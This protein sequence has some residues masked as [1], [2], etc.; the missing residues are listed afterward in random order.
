MAAM[1]PTRLTLAPLDLRP[2]VLRLLGAIV[3]LEFVPG[4]SALYLIDEGSGQV[5]V[6][7]SGNGYNGTLGSTAGVDA[8]TDPVRVPGGGVLLGTGQYAVIPRTTTTRPAMS[9]FVS[10]ACRAGT[11]AF[12]KFQAGAGKREWTIRVA[13]NDLHVLV[14]DNGT[15]STHYKD[16]TVA[17][18]LTAE[19]H[20]VGFTFIAGV[21]TLYL[22]GVPQTP[23]AI[24]ADHPIT[25]V[26]GSTAPMVIGG[27]YEAG[28]P[29]NTMSGG[30][31]AAAIVYDSAALAPTQALQVHTYLKSIVASR[32][33][34]PPQIKFTW[35][36][37]GIAIRDI[38]GR[39]VV[40]PSFS[41][42]RLAEGKAYYVD[43][44]AGSDADTGLSA[45]HALA[46]VGAALAKADIDTLYIMS[47]VYDA[48]ETVGTSIPRPLNMIGV[49]TVAL[50]C[51]ETP[52][53]L[54]WLKTAGK[55]NVYECTEASAISRIFDSTVP[56]ATSGDWS[57]LALQTSTANVDANAGS[58]Y[59]DGTTLY[60]HTHDH[61]TPDAGVYIFLAGLRCLNNDL[62]MNMY[63]E[64]ITFLGGDAPVY[65]AN[66]A[67][68]LIPSAAMVRCTAK[69]SYGSGFTV[70]GASTFFEE[71][72]AASNRLDG[73]NYHIS[74]TKV[75]Y[76]YEAGCIGRDNGLGET[77][78]SDQGSST[79][80]GGAIVRVNGE[81][82]RNAGQNI[83]DV[84]AGTRSWN[85]GCYAHDS[86]GANDINFDALAG[87]AM[88][89]HR[90][91][92][93][94]SATDL[95][96]AAAAT[97]YIRDTA[98][99]AQVVAGSVNDY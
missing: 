68:S 74:N 35:T 52:E 48:A 88:W 33:I 3:G 11:T 40:S 80:D 16:Y 18:V 5:L 51:H 7:S 75:C 4:Y 96:V 63:V 78:D 87:C 69:Y 82:C 24:A 9:A 53:N 21:L 54:S 15:Y 77:S 19:Y 67:A 71:C 22:D 60:V 81:Y 41:A 8:A 17:D 76:S 36:P 72:V 38:G 29:I 43:K 57:M 86:T 25:T 31:V 37:P 23:T 84:T 39:F 26:F 2:T 61:R 50:G 94:G 46:T 99:P 12:S 13:G 45:D 70:L 14:S 73:F 97:A 28:G 44:A 89:L 79:H 62:G 30:G 56:N 98:L 49:G 20:T 93:A 65:L 66:H 85:L 64:N 58:Y 92:S 10:V 95:N 1:E 55:T 90:C 6:D 83:A 42:F 91:V 47:G 34:V 59:V 27:E 32:G